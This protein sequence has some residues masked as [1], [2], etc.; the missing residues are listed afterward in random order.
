MKRKSSLIFKILILVLIL[1]IL[2][3]IFQ[4]ATTMRDTGK[5][6][7]NASGGFYSTIPEIK[8]T[9]MTLRQFEDSEIKY[10]L[11]IEGTNTNSGIYGFVQ[12]ITSVHSLDKYLELSREFMNSNVFN[13]N[14]KNVLFGEISGRQWTYR[15]GKAFTKQEFYPINQTDILIF[16]LSTTNEIKNNTAGGVAF[17]ELFNNIVNGFK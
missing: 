12:I 9:V 4:Y 8:D 1:I 5:N 16:S 2:Y 6:M 11:D 3:M 13:L 15:T 7:V 10:H 14:E 17:E